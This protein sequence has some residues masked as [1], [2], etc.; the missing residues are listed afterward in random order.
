[1]RKRRSEIADEIVREYYRELRWKQRIAEMEQKKEQ[2][3]KEKTLTI[4]DKLI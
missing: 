4:L 2:E 1:M 3:E